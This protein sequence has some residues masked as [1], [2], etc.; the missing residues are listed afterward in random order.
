MRF[1]FDNNLSPHL[2]RAMHSLSE[3][4]GHSVVHLREKFP[5]NVSDTEWIEGLAAEGHWIVVSG[6][7]NIH[8]ARLEKAVWRNAKLVGF[9]LARGWMN[10]EPLDQAWRLV[11]W[12]PA[13]LRQ[14]GLAAPGSTYLLS[15]N[16]KQVVETL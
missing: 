2:A 9:F 12:W 7:L 1:F 15:V 6:D 8:R 10:L 14:A 4:D 11:K 16:A 13:V 3:P 5:Q